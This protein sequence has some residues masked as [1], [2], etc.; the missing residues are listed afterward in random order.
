MFPVRLLDVTTSYTSFVVLTPG[1]YTSETSWQSSGKGLSSK[2]GDQPYFV[3]CAIVSRTLYDIRH[4]LRTMLLLATILTLGA[5]V[6]ARELSPDE[7]Q[8]VYDLAIADSSLS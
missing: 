8:S 7:L 6:G 4:S 2:H 5:L 1:L 3:V